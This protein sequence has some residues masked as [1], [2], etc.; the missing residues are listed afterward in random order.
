[1]ADKQ[2]IILR[3]KSRGAEHGD[4]RTVDT[5]TAERLVSEGLADYPPTSKAAKESS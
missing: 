1:M 4:R 5:E 2:Q 3:G